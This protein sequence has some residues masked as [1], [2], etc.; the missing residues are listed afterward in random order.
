MRRL[1]AQRR[2][3]LPWSDRSILLASLLL[4]LLAIPLWLD[5]Q[6]LNEVTG[7]GAST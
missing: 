6:T 4:V 3:S 5:P 2:R 1:L 7:Q